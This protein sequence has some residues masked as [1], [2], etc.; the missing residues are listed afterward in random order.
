MHT[1]NVIHVF[2]VI[3][4][5]TVIIQTFRHVGEESD[6]TTEL[7]RQKGINDQSTVVTY[8]VKIYYT[9]EFKDDTPDVPLFLDQVQ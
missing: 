7:L 5:Q 9:Q 4:T 1:V 2:G 8:T 3:Y 6:R